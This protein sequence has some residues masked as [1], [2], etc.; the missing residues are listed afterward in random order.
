MKESK[1]AA[2]LL[3]ALLMTLPA[4]ASCGEDT[5]EETTADTSVSETQTTETEP[6]WQYPE[7]DFEGASYRIYNMDN[8]YNMYVTMNRD[9]LN[10][11]I[12]DDAV[13]NRN[14]GVEEALNCVI[15]EILHVAPDCNY[16]P[17][18]TTARSSVLGGS[19]DYEIMYLPVSEQ[20]SLVTDGILQDL[21]TIPH[22]QLNETWWDNQINTTNTLN[23]KLYFASGSANL[24]AF[25]GMWC[26]FFNENL[27][28]EYQLEK[29]YDLVREGKW[30]LDELIRYGSAFANLN[31]ESTY[32]YTVG[33]KNQWGVAL[34]SHF[35]GAPAKFIHGAGVETL[36]E[37]FQLNIEND[38]FYSVM[39][40]LAI[41]MNQDSGIAL[42]AGTDDFNVEQGGYIYI[43]NSRRSLFLTAEI[44]TAQVLRD[45]E[46]TFG[47][48]PYP[49]YDEA[50]EDYQTTLVSQLMYLTVPTTNTNLDLTATVSEVMAHDSYENV[51]PV[52]YSS[53]VE[54]KGLRNEDSIEMLEIMRANRD[55]DIAVVFSWNNSIREQV[56]EKL[57]KGDNQV[58]SIMAA[59]KSATESNIQKFM[60]FLNQ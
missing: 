9:E 58:A 40:K 20:I 11:N 53:V 28:D 48:L 39:D 4:L 22:L 25:D 13:Y 7:K 32:A 35:G 1:R 55:V 56:R 42:K 34:H 45:M 60:E 18:F 8:F 46:D 44:K 5:A 51:I 21:Y 3:A 2:A 29:P 54:H 12:L 57:F 47:I 6:Q 19:D 15:T 52:Y 10:G 26:L 14:R 38:H 24:M 30:T 33:S 41:L 31:G 59:Q 43:F 16:Q 27:M 49:K 23:G 50:Q 17:M 37:D 36:T